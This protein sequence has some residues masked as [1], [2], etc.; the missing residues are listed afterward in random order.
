MGTTERLQYH[1]VVDE[2]CQLNWKA[3]IGQDMIHVAWAYYYF[4]IQFRENLKVARALYPFD[5]NLKDLEREECETDNLSPWPGVAAVGESMNHDEYMR[6]VLKIQ[7]V[8]PFKLRNI[9]A[10]GERYLE[11]VRELDDTSRALRIASYEDGGF[12]SV[13]RAILGFDH[14]D[15]AL[16]RAFQH[17]LSEHVRFDSDPDHGHGA[18]SRHLR[19]DDR[20]VPLWQAFKD[21]LVTCVPGLSA[22]PGSVHVRSEFE[23][24]STH[25]GTD[26]QRHFMTVPRSTAPRHG[27]ATPHPARWRT[28]SPPVH[29]IPRQP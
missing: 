28:R 17:F 16:L 26:R 9:N 5:E 13:F 21:I 7:S 18:L 2:I 22:G 3:L 14:W 24:A 10:V 20:V 6:R 12:E 29:G 23:A 27:P 8:D 15:D 1:L 19:P 11:F 4:S 25:P